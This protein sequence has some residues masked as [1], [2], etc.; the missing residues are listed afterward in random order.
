MSGRLPND[1]LREKTCE[2]LAFCIEHEP[3]VFVRGVAVETVQE[4][5]NVKFGLRSSAVEARDQKAVD[6]GASRA[7]KYLNEEAK[8][9]N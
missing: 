2:A 9:N 5:W 6:R 4:I 1:I 7:L 8:L 3:D